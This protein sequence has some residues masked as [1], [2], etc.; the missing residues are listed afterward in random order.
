MSHNNDD[1][2]AFVGIRWIRVVTASIK[3]NPWPLWTSDP[4]TT[5]MALVTITQRCH[6]CHTK[7]SYKGVIQAKQPPTQVS[8]KGVIQ[9]KQPPTQVSYKPPTQVSYA[10]VIKQ[11]KVSCKGRK[12]IQA[13]APLEMIPLWG[14]R[15]GHQA[16]DVCMRMLGSHRRYLHGPLPHTKNKYN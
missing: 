1:Y 6:K 13:S 8:Y 16:N 11:V 5:P 3:C 2:R 7:V 12:C 9:A 15:A 14:S 4:G 10:D